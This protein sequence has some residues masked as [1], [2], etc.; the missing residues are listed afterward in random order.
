MGKNG[1]QMTSN[2]SYE[3]F[4][5][6]TSNESYE[7]NEKGTNKLS[8]H[9]RDYMIDKSMRKLKID[10]RWRSTVARGAN[11]LSGDRFW[12]LVEYSERAKAP[13]RYFIKSLNREMWK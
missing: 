5:K 3:K 6:R 4:S 9:E 13:A 7:S 8:I 10:E 11:R 1:H 12:T 2:E